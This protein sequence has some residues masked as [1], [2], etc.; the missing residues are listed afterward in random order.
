MVLC[1]PRH[2]PELLRDWFKQLQ[3]MQ[4]ECP[5][6]PF[7]NIVCVH[8]WIL[9]R[10]IYGGAVRT[11]PLLLRDMRQFCLHL[12]LLQQCSVPDAIRQHLPVY[13]RVLLE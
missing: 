10:F 5:A 13:R 2:L 9:R 7:W 6:D 8:D 11:V 1:V 3:Y 4:R 12:H